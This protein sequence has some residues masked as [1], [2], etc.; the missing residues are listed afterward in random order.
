VSKWE[1]GKLGDYFEITSSKRVFQ[2]DWTDKG[3]PFYRAR[4]I[5]KLSVDDFVDNELF[6]T[7][8]MYDEY[9]KKYGKPNAGDIMVTG[10]GTLG[11]CYVVKNSDKFYFKDGNIIWLKKKSNIESNYVKWA[12]KSNLV[13]D[14]IKRNSS[15]TTVGTYTIINAKKTIIPIPP[16]DTQIQI[17]KTLDLVAGLLDM[18]KQ[19]LTE[20]DNLIKSTFFDMFGDPVTNEIGWEIRSLKEVCNKITDGTHH[21]PDNS[22]VGEF[23]YIT[24]KNIKK[25][26][27]DLNNL[28]FISASAHKGIYSR[29]NPQFGD[30][31]YIKD[32]VTTGIAQINSLNE[33]FSMLSS[34]ALLK[35]N[36]R[37]IN[38]YYLREVLN[39]EVMYAEI[40]RDMGGAAITRL[41]IKKIEKI[42]IPIPPLTHQNQFADIVTK[43]EEQKALVKKAIE[44]TQHLFDSLMS[45]YFE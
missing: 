3:V 8:H 36:N 15:G 11:T 7:E 10:V 25:D 12:F 16:L 6:I 28:T 41:T 18:R 17:A 21:S 34:V 39:N 14:Q 40:R 4:E 32:G 38:A 45:E 42:R 23:K 5:A 35:Q 13:K 26:G 20:L 24:A 9:S 22:D 1:M 43:I 44:E 27:F 19:Q 37:I 33:E 30:V 29:C 31:L 2:S